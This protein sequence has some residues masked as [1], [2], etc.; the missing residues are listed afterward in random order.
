MQKS[1]RPADTPPLADMDSPIANAPVAL[2]V[3]QAQCWVDHRCTKHTNDVTKLR[4]PNDDKS[5]CFFVRA[6]IQQR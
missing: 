2:S 6:I 5:P 4:R 1:T 3:S